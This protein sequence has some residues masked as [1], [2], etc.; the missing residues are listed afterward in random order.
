MA[1]KLEERLLDDVLGVL[2]VA[3]QDR[4]EAVNRRAVLPE[5]PACRL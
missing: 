5:K 4:G 1:Q 3:H 2:V